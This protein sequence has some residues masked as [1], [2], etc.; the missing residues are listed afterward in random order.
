[1]IEM[2]ILNQDEICQDIREE[3]SLSR[4]ALEAKVTAMENIR[5]RLK[6]RIDV[7]KSTH[8]ALL[9]K[10][11]D[12]LLPLDETAPDYDTNLAL[13]Q[14]ANTSLID[15]ATLLS[16]SRWLQSGF[17][18][19][20]PLGGFRG[21]GLLSLECMVFFVHEYKDKA[22]AMMERNALPGGNRYPFPVAA[23]NVMRMMLKLLMLDQ[24]PAASSKLI[25]HAT[26]GDTRDTILNMQVA[27]RVSRTPFWKIFDDAFAFEKLHSMAFMVLDLHWLRS[28]ATQMGFNPVQIH[29][30]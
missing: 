23:I 26:A 3:M 14:Q 30:L 18:T 17:H 24:E 15:V 29:L 25:L 16:S 4:A 5:R 22:H 7:S 2:L 21:G 20:D 9:K 11:W 19:K 12:A 13:A 6:E 10:L 1:M 28:G 8:V 27:E